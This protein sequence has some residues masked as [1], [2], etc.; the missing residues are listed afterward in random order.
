MTETAGDTSGTKEP[1]I[2]QNKFLLRIRTPNFPTESS[3]LTLRSSCTPKSESH[4]NIVL[5]HERHIVD[6]GYG[7]KGDTKS[8]A[9]TFEAFVQQHPKNGRDTDSTNL[10]TSVEALQK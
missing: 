10:H 1:Q 9:F 3:I 8:F 5:L 7:W 6:F 2:P 4:L